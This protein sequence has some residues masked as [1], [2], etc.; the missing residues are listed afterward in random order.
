MAVADMRTV[1]VV[2]VVVVVYKMPYPDIIYL[3]LLSTGRFRQRS[4][5]TARQ[6]S[7]LN[8]REDLQDI[9]FEF[10]SAVSSRPRI[11]KHETPNW[12]GYG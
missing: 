5:I 6:V 2:V 12:Q 8:Q 11:P 3:M 10:L 4:K 7:D 1:V 9:R